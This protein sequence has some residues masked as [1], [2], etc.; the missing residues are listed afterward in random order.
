MREG[1]KRVGEGGVEPLPG[2]PDRILNPGLA[3]RGFRDPAIIGAVIDTIRRT[4]R[5]W[6]N[7]RHAWFRTMCSK[8][9][10]GSNPLARTVLKRSLLNTGRGWSCP[11]YAFSNLSPD[12]RLMFTHACDSVGL[13]W[14]TSDRTV[15]VSRKADVE[16]MDGFVG[17]K[18]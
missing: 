11:R 4:A 9:R 5:A 15:Y 1:R 10:G 6:W 18:A 12:I 13:R 16:R 2:C 14:T 3:A 7:G 17:P 8:E